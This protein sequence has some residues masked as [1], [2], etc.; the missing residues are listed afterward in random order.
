MPFNGSGSFSPY[1]P[2][3]PAVSGTTISSTAFNNTVTDF[4]AGLSNAMTRDGQSPATANIPMGGK[5]ITGLGD[6]S[7][8]TDAATVGQTVTA[9]AASS[10]A[11]AASSG[12]SLVGYLP[13]GTGA[14]ATTVQSKLRESI[15]VLGFYANGSS[16]VRVD[17]TGVTE[18]YLGV[19]AA[20]NSLA[21]SGVVHFPNLGNSI[22]KLSG[23]ITVPI[24]VSLDF[25]GSTIDISSATGPVFSYNDTPASFSFVATS[26]L[27]SNGKII[28]NSANLSA[29]PF[30][31][32]RIPYVTV[33]DVKLFTCNVADVYGE[34]ILLNFDNVVNYSPIAT[35]YRFQLG[36][37]AFGPNGAVL[38]SCYIEE[39]VNSG[40]IGL[41]VNSGSVSLRGC[42]LEALQTHLSI[43]GGDVS[44]HETSFNLRKFDGTAAFIFTSVTAG[45]TFILDDCTFNFG[46]GTAA[47]SMYGFIVNCPLSIKMNGNLFSSIHN[48]ASSS[49]VFALRN[50][51]KGVMDSNRFYCLGTSALQT[52][53]DMGNASASV[54][55]LNFST[56]SVYGEFGTNIKFTSS[57]PL[58]PV[59]QCTITGNNFLRLSSMLKLNGGLISN[60][61]FAGNAIV[62][63]WD[64][65]QGGT[66]INNTFG[67]APSVS[68]VLRAADNTGYELGNTQS[69]RI[70][71]GAIAS[72]A[73]ANVTVTWP[74]AWPGTLYTV[75]AIV[76]EVTGG[77]QTLLVD[78]CSAIAAGTATFVIKNNSAGSLTGTL[79]A[80]ATYDPS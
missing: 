2:G 41:Q 68:N 3:N 18:S 9:L 17:S 24:G 66:L 38:N 71:T 74:R 26:T 34:C 35:S 30:K 40:V 8:A 75:S 21:G 60:N 27:I 14:V 58:G 11:L 72:G 49:N 16:G 39:A 13:V 54:D 12:S 78:H 22:Y 29:Y 28:G 73:Y 57:S 63:Q 56:N 65:G 77:T 7:A 48:A 1:T 55:Y 31:F 79:Y 6:G 42:Y 36:T 19:Q 46:E 47:Y 15:S 32:D 76:L 52:I 44:V 25:N 51:I 64:V 20:I 10:T 23:K 43:N 4:A 53:F 50:S 5:K 37:G 45:S 67:T 80:T 69:T 62:I 59:T 70:T 61:S 33:R